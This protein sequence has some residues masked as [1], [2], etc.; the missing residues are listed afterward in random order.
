MGKQ[1]ELNP[2]LIILRDMG[3]LSNMT[4]KIFMEIITDS[5]Q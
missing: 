1:S 4:D 2:D 3:L 5:K